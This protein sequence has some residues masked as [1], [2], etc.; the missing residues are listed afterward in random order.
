MYKAKQMTIYDV[1]EIVADYNTEGVSEALAKE[2]KGGHMGFRLIM[3]GGWALDLGGYDSAEEVVKER[4][5]LRAARQRAYLDF[6][7]GYEVPYCGVDVAEVAHEEAKG[8]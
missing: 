7:M 3:K 6:N 5:A 2:G 1:R 8:V 4:E